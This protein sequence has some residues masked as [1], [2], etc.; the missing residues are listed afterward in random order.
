MTHEL[1]AEVDRFNPKSAEDR[2]AERV[3]WLKSQKPFGVPGRYE[4]ENFIPAQPPNMTLA[5]ELEA[6]APEVAAEM[7]A[8]AT[9]APPSEE[10]I[11]QQKQAAAQAQAEA[12]LRS[13]QHAHQFRGF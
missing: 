10:Q 6:L 12:Q 3:E 5:F 9:P 1:Q 13:V 4:G 2:N 8:E 7:K 11:Y